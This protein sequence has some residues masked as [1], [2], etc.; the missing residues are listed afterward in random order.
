M[1]N[2]ALQD[3]FPP[4]LSPA[5]SSELPISTNLASVSFDMC[6]SQAAVQDVDA[7]MHY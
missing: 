4:P 7:E 6:T 3:R 2:R 5:G 1:V